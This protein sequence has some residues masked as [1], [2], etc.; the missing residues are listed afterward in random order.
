M[1]SERIFIYLQEMC[2]PYPLA[3]A[4]GEAPKRDEA[5]GEAAAGGSAKAMA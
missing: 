2:F 1:V 3:P 4:G 5:E